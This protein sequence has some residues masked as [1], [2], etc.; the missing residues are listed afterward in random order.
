MPS[1]Q[2]STTYQNG[3]S[4]SGTDHLNDDKDPKQ[5]ESP[6]RK[7]QKTASWLARSQLTREFQ[8][9]NDEDELGKLMGD[10]GEKLLAFVDDIR[11]IESFRSIELDIPQVPRIPMYIQ[12]EVSADLVEVGSRWRHEHWEIFS[13]P[14]PN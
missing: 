12:V 6:V 4:G 14:S 2:V 5:P 11:K 3:Q 9:I 8:S 7:L 13:P 10:A 1:P